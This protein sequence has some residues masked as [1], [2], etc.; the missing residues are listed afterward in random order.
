MTNA[1]VPFHPAGNLYYPPPL[2]HY[3]KDLAS[4]A[5]LQRWVKPQSKLKIGGHVLSVTH[6]KDFTL[7]ASNSDYAKF[8]LIAAESCLFI[9]LIS[10]SLSAQPFG[11][12]WKFVSEMV[13][14]AVLPCEAKE[15]GRLGQAFSFHAILNPKLK[16][17]AIFMSPR[18]TVFQ[19]QVNVAHLSTFD[20]NDKQLLWKE[21]HNAFFRLAA[22]KA[23]EF[24]FH[25]DFPPPSPPSVPNA[26]PVTTCCSS[27]IWKLSVKIIN[28]YEEQP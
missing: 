13:R 10:S 25:G 26:S 1:C 28:M 16:N 2:H 11:K 23:E 4:C 12:I 6:L 8:L 18:L 19:Q 24:F 14:R 27:R 17:T 22:R 9:P 20:A 15:S 21:E 5:D 3:C 7:S